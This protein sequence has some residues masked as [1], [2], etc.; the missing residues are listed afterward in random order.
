ML[1][2]EIILVILGLS[3][4]VIIIRNPREILLDLPFDFFNLI[5]SRLKLTCYL[6]FVFPFQALFF[7]IHLIFKV[8]A[9]KPE[10]WMK[11]T[12]SGKDVFA[13]YIDYDV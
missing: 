13:D 9:Y 2:V 12:P 11:I 8:K 7:L 3:A 5:W 6:I 4:L 1:I 10:F